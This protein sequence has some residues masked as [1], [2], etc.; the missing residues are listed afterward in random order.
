MFAQDYRKQARQALTGQWGTMAVIY[1]VYVVISGILAYTY[2][3]NLLLG[4]VLMLGMTS[5]ALSL[6]RTGT[7][8]A[9]YL[10][11]GF[12]INLTNAL[13]AS[14]LY[15]LY[16]ILWSLLFVIPGIVKL[17]SYSMTFYILRDN[18]EMSANDA[19]TASRQMMNGNKFR[20][21]CLQ[22]SF[23]GWI[24]LACL[25]C[26]IGFFFVFPY[27]QTAQA[28]FYESLRA[29]AKE[30]PSFGGEAQGK[31]FYDEYTNN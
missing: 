4:G 23:I 16:I 25:T 12:K 19:I 3:G 2:V 5:V 24:L 21:F 9:E 31:S 26:G 14:V 15:N 10:F 29:P 13:V 20:L 27:M 28:A 22:L 11:D 8:R 7:T 1:L 30:E 17:Y 18:P 6:L